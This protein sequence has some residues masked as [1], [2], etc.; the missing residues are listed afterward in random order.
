VRFAPRSSFHAPEASAPYI[1]IIS[2][3]E[4]ST[5]EQSMTCPRPVERALMM[6]AKTPIAR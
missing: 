5:I 1:I 2:E 6:P 3:A 4:P